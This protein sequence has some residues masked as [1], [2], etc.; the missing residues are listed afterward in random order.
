[1][2]QQTPGWNAGKNIN[3]FGLGIFL[4]ELASWKGKMLK[5]IYVVLILFCGPG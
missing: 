5:K 3:V 1:M 2:V 4:Q